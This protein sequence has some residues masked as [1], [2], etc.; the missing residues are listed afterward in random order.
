MTVSNVS[1]KT[2]CANL[3]MT[4]SSK[5]LTNNGLYPQKVS[6]SRVLHKERTLPHQR[7][8]NNGSYS[9][10]WFDSYPT[11]LSPMKMVECLY[12]NVDPPPNLPVQ[13]CFVK[14]T[15]Y[16]W[17][18]KSYSSYTHFIHSLHIHIHSYT[19][20]IQHHPYIIALVVPSLVGSSLSI[21]SF[22]L[23]SSE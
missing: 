17:S 6:A 8:I 3:Q 15:C 14:F 9:C 7:L 1:T 13:P 19:T 23:V 5:I 20:C 21:R 16:M 12:C 2:L 10:Q 18:Y 22:C 11:I 4:V